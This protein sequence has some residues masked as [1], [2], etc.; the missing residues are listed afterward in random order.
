MIAA[1]D[2]IRRWRFSVLD[3]DDAEFWLSSTGESVYE[4]D[5][6]EFLGTDRQAAEEGERLS[7]L[8][9]EREDGFV[10]QVTYHS[11]G[12]FKESRTPT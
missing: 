8:W 2:V 11:R 4:D 7:D 6:V 9:E 1:T 5:A 3:W 10:A 12:V